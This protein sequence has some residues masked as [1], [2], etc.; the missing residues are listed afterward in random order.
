MPAGKPNAT[1]EFII[2]VIVMNLSHFITQKQ[3]KQQE[4]KLAW[5][6]REK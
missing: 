5:K 4:C 6:S 1:L 2:Q 3:S